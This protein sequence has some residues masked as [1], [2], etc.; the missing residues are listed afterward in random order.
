M[1]LFFSKS[2]CTFAHGGGGFPPLPNLVFWEDKNEES[3]AC[4]SSFIASLVMKSQGIK[5]VPQTKVQF[6]IRPD[7]QG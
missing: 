6:P 7:P 2:G 1:D 5:V 3:E 4:S